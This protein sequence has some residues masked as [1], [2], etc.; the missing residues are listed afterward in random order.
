MD[1]P[2]HLFALDIGTRS[3]VGLVGEQD[4]QIIRIVGYERQE[5]HTRAMLD[6]QIH[7]VVE[8]AKVIK[9]VKRRLEEQVGPL[10]QVSVA[11][12][13]RALCT[14]KSSAEIDTF[15]NN[16]LTVQDETSLELAAI[17]NAQRQLAT[18][19]S[20]PNPTDYYCVGYS[21]ISFSLDGLN[22]KRLVGQRGKVANAEIIATFLPRQ[23]I[24]SLESAV[25][26][27]DLEIATLTLEPI[28]SI[29]VL[30][31]PT[32]RHLNLALVD[33]GAGTSDVALTK[34]GSVVAYGMVPC[35]GD[36]ITEA[37]SQKYL[38]DFNVAEQIKRKLTDDPESKI[39]FVDVLG[40]SHELTSSEIISSIETTVNDLA[41]AIAKEILTLNTA[42]PQA[43][44]LVG[45]GSLTPLLPKAVAHALELDEMRVAIRRPESIEDIPIIPD[46]LKAPDFVTPL[47]ILKLSTSRHLNF[48]S[49][50]LNNTPLKVFN[51]GHL[52]V[53]D[54]LLAGGINVRELKG[55]PGLGLTLTLNGTT[56]FVPGKHG[57]MGSI[58]INGKQASY[59][60]EIHDQDELIVKKGID[61]QSPTPKVQDLITLPKP[62][63]VTINNKPYSIH[64]LITVNGKHA[65][66]ETPLVDR[67]EIVCHKAQ[68][69][70]EVLQLTN[71]DDGQKEYSYTI[72]GSL[73][74]YL[75]EAKYQINHRRVERTATVAPLDEIEIE[76]PVV[77]KLY[78]VLGLTT[79][80]SEY[81]TVTFNNKPCQV[82]VQSWHIAVNGETKRPE[83]EAPDGSLIH[84]TTT[85]I[86]P[87]LSHVMLAANFT[88][89]AT[90]G[91]SKIEV[92]LNGVA[93]EYTS[94]VKSGDQIAVTIKTNTETRE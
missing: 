35:A 36:E 27:V 69:L 55:H 74:S 29:H 19:D 83:D 40:L 10:G 13:G 15:N 54:A 31:P 65:L 56:T 51:L 85:Q 23:V 39:P 68:T 58:T 33:I 4:G 91:A 12:A 77:P 44:L 88:P 41:Q 3:V 63:T 46:E 72:N 53:A 18:S 64:P 70:D 48:I 38:L 5:H 78:Q 80:C 89:L 82:P 47:G 20:I 93:A 37:I 32:M 59:E 26:S 79:D 25:H 7:D 76:Y 92:L 90:S 22:L 34:S 73:R 84:C 62:W 81:M 11:A 66:P 14:I 43:V 60:A 45:G 6:G 1:T 71:Y 57:E 2:Q 67:D 94:L 8:V 30:I 86:Q 42:P 24:D 49:I 28:A 9:D 52:S 17:Q 75:V 21:V 61:G 16:I 50:T 87:M